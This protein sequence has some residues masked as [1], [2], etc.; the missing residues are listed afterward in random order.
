[1]MKRNIKVGTPSSV[2]IYSALRG[3]AAVS[4]LARMK[5]NNSTRKHG[6]SIQKM[7]TGS[8][9]DWQVSVRD[10]RPN[11]SL[12]V[13]NEHNIRKLNHWMNFIDLKKHGYSVNK[14][15]TSSLGDIDQWSCNQVK[16]VSFKDKFQLILF[17]KQQEFEIIGDFQ[18]NDLQ[19]I[20][21]LYGVVKY[22][23]YTNTGGHHCSDYQAV[24]RFGRGRYH[25][26]IYEYDE[27]FCVESHIDAVDPKNNPLGHGK[28]YLRHRQGLMKESNHHLIS[29]RKIV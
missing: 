19:K 13:R 15:I 5:G 17:L 4:R 2:I 9:E 24:K 11:F 8:R 6:K 12:A 29:I 21:Y 10:G 7:V 28:E 3:L 25:L 22:G 27:H 18:G 20:I 26:R 23:N 1:M 16:M 14:R